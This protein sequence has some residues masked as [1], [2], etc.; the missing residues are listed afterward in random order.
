MPEVR[1]KDGESQSVS[2]AELVT[3]FKRRGL[4]DELR[5]DQFNEF[6]QSDDHDKL[7]Q[8]IKKI[9]EAEVSKDPEIL[10]R[11]RGKATALLE[12]AVSRR[13]D[14]QKS[15]SGYV[16]A[17]TIESDDLRTHL[18]S[19]INQYYEESTKGTNNGN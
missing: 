3:L 7:R 2:A 11:N 1:D 8:S 18:R 12:G 16:D 19:V 17:N 5:R 10:E 13:G 9:V 14:V 4:L 15:V 6:K